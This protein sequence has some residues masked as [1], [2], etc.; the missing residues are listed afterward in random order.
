MNKSP[1][2]NFCPLTNQQPYQRETDKPRQGVA[3]NALKLFRQRLG[4]FVVRLGDSLFTQERKLIA[5]WINK[6]GQPCLRLG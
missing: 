4:G 6:L 3:A 2:E 5:I 1:P